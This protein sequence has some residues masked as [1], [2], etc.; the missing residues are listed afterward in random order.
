MVNQYVLIF[1]TDLQND[2]LLC[3]GGNALHSL[4][5]DGKEVLLRVGLEQIVGGIHTEGLHRV[6]GGGC[7]KD[8]RTVHTLGAQLV[9]TLMPE[10][11]GM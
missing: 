7:Q 2:A 11:P 8:N 4:V 5:H 1:S 9:A 10:T 3:M 6:L